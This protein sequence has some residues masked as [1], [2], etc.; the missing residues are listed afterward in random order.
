MTDS[1]HRGVSTT[2]GYVLMLSVASLLVV[3]LLTAGGGFVAE[4]REEVI[5]TELEVV[6]QQLA[7]DI[8]AAD[9]MAEASQ[10]PPSNIAVRIVQQ[11]PSDVTGSTYDVT[12]VAD[13]DP[14]L[15][16]ESADPSV[17]VTVDLTN[18]TAVRQSSVGGGEVAVVYDAS[19]D[20]LVI[21]RV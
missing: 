9:R 13:A 16:L 18:S 1:R 6:G 15:R 7:S 11:R 17:T 20:E 8:A 10:G 5:R 12:L 19:A 14:Q 3:G 21:E 4:Q 2:L